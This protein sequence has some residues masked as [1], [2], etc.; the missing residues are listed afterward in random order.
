MALTYTPKVQLGQPMP[1]FSSELLS[2]QLYSNSN[3]S[4]F[5]YKV[6]GFIC[7][8]CP[9]VQA[10]ESRLVALQNKLSPLN[11][12]FLAVCSNDPNE[13]PED[14]RN[15]LIERAKQKSYNFNYV[16]DESQKIATDFGA[17]CTPDFF[18]FD[19]ENH[20]FY[21]GRLDDS[22]R[23]AQKVQREDLLE[24]VR[25]HKNKKPIDEQIP[26]MGCSIKWKA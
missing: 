16:F 9:Y 20:L 7:G 24:A 18:V 6:I 4:S 3:L 17:V 21:R 12:I 22:W 8:H 23:D 25:D 2:G 11:G 26:S 1:E 5:E 19:K 14:S 15:A 13:Y 10:I